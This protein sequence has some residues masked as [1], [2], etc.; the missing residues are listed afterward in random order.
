MLAAKR[1]SSLIAET[2]A[3]PAA[4]SVIST[5]EPE[6]APPILSRLS[7]ERPL[8]PTGF[9]S[10]KSSL[11]PARSQTSPVT[12][13]PATGKTALSDHDLIVQLGQMPV[14]LAAPL[15]R[16][17]LGA[18]DTPALLA[19]VAAT[20]EAHQKIVARRDDLDW[21]VV[22]A[23]IKSNSDE[24]LLALAENHALSFDDDDQAALVRLAAD[25]VML[26]AAILAN[27]ALQRIHGQLKLNTDDGLSHRNMRLVR[28]LRAGLTTRF[29]VE[30]AW[31][32]DW[33]ASSLQRVLT[34]PSAIP[35]ALLSCALGLD[36][37]VF[38]NLLP[39]WQAANNG[40]PL[41]NAAH[42]PMILSV[43]SLNPDEA[44]RKLAA[45]ARN[46]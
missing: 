1:K 26:R 23:L 39:H 8:P 37:A 5:A 2:T 22:K 40:E 20:G 32:L 11:Y 13:A 10:Y 34:G 43:F 3:K 14:D 19:L 33:E 25:R 7:V 36:R 4:E 18:L 21:R 17:S 16:A 31:R 35:L 29:V 27:P 30:A 24:V 15:L 41:C 28:F 38:L 12:R 45:I 44:G 6:S 46:L 9:A 42:K